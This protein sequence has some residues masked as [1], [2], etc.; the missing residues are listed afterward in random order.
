MRELRA[1]VPLFHYHV[2]EKQVALLLRG[3]LLNLK[4]FL[5]DSKLVLESLMSKVHLQLSFKYQI[6]YTPLGLDLGHF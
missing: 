6:K 1:V 4:Y 5:C 2:I 3:R